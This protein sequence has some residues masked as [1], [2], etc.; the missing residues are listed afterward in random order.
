MLNQLLQAELERFE[1]FCDKRSEFCLQ[2]CHKEKDMIVLKSFLSESLTRIAQAA[3][4]EALDE[5]V[6]SIEGMEKRNGYNNDGRDTYAQAL[7]SIKSSIL[8]VL[9][10]EE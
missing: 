5:V 10:D 9:K 6:K 3:R 8:E 7:S 2:S 1:K 4:K